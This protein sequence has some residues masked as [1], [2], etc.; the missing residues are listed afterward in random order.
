MSPSPNSATTGGRRYSVDALTGWAARVFETAGVCAVDA[1]VTAALLVRSDLRGVDTHGLS[2][3]K[4]YLTR[5]TSGDFNPRPQI[6]IERRSTIWNIDGDG[7]LGQVA[8][9]LVIEESAKALRDQPMLWVNLREAGHL[10]ALGMFALA[11]AERGFVCFLGQRT[12]PLLG[13]PGFHGR[14]LGHNPFAFGAPVGGG[15]PP[16]VLDMAC[17]VAARGHI[18]LAARAGEA[19]PET[20][21]V[22]K[23]GQP[24]TNAAEAA[25]GM[26]RPTG[27]Y[28]GMGIAMM[29]ECLAAA[30]S[31]TA[32]SNADPIM[33]IPPD[34]AI[35]RQSAFFLFLSPALVDDQSA[36]L[37]YMQ[38]WI[39]FYREAGGEAAQIPGAR[40]VKLEQ[41]G[42]AAGL[43]YSPAVEDELIAL[44]A[45][46]G[47]PFPAPVSTPV[48]A[49]GATR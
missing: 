48:S 26:L 44:G 6:R 49:S 47:Q 4:S 19:I 21:A 37:H 30:L 38:H 22:T 10:G 2:R 34:G 23:D 13:L 20:W 1:K 43:A 42:L 46:L 25:E 16:F 31:A 5:L 28:K 17:S 24:T 3:L 9:H 39:S 41:S 40:G 15:E 11:A 45:S 12:P 7:A 29:I 8:G 27:D 14:A 36:F 35:R 32:P 33:Y 18:L